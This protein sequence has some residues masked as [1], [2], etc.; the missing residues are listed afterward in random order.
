MVNLS[1]VT[2]YWMIY[3]AFGALLAMILLF[4]FGGILLYNFYMN[5]YIKTTAVIDNLEIYKFSDNTYNIDIRYSYDVGGKIYTS[6]VY[7]L[8]SLSFYSEKDAEQN[9]NKHYTGTI[10]DDQDEINIYYNPQN[11]HE[12]YVVEHDMKN[13]LDMI[14]GWGL[15]A[16]GVFAGYIS[17]SYYYYRNNTFVSTTEIL[18]ETVAKN[19]F[20]KSNRP[21]ISY[22]V[23]NTTISMRPS[24][25]R[26]RSSFNLYSNTFN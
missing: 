10:I 6:D 8:T 12:S 16:I 7:S 3:K 22:N 24:L 23:G 11:P 4:I 13:N 2:S 21:K 14:V 25:F 20:N 18:S 17:W 26:R 9:I 5:K 19:A 1:N 15:V